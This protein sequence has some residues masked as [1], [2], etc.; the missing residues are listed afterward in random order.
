VIA[1]HITN[2]QKTLKID[3]RRMRQAVRA[4][5]RDAG[6]AEATISIAIVD[7]ATIAKLH[8]QFLDV[9]EPTDVLSFVLERTE[10]SLEGEV[11]ASADTARACAS[12]FHLTP[13]NE[14]LLYVIHGTL[15]LVGYGDTTSRRRAVMRKK[16]MEYLRIDAV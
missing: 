11:V 9:P 14:L 4:I 16:E 12:R 2:R 1:I 3:R 13:E 10:D 7:N 8:Q 5:V 15:H 6:I